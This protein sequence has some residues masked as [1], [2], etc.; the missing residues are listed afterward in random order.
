MQRE[1][2][3]KP[4]NLRFKFKSNVIRKNWVTQRPDKRGTDVVA[5][6]DSELLLRLGEEKR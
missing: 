2:I 6:L 4:G 3:V 1:E 5:S